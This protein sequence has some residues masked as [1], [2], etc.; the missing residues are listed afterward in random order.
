MENFV[1]RY[2]LEEAILEKDNAV[3]I[4]QRK[5]CGLQAEMRIIVK[6]NSELS[7][8]LIC[9]NEKIATPSC[10]YSCPGGSVS[11]PLLTAG[12]PDTP[13]NN[14]VTQLNDGACCCRCCLEDRVGDCSTGASRLA[15]GGVDEHLENNILRGNMSCLSPSDTKASASPRPL[16]RGTC[17]AEL[18]NIYGQNTKNLEEQLGNIESEVRTMQMELI[19][20]QRERNQLDQQRKLFKC[21]GPCVPCSCNPTAAEPI[22]KTFQSLNT[23]VPCSPSLQNGANTIFPTKMNLPQDVNQGCSLNSV[24]SV[25]QCNQ[26][27][28]RDL[29]EQYARLQDDYKSKLCEVSCLRSDAEKM[30]QE[31]RDVKEEKAKIENKLIDLQERLKV[32]EI[33]K[34]KLSGNKEQMIEQ[35]QALIVA[36]QR[37]RDAQDELDELRSLTQDQC[38]QLE[39]YRNK[40]LMAQQKVEEQRHQLD[41][42]ELDNVRM[43]ENVTLEIGRV[44]NQF[45]DKLAELAPLPD[46]LKQT[47]LKLQE[48]QQLR[49]ISERHCDDLSREIFDYKDKIESIQK[50]MDILRSENITL[51]GDCGEGSGKCEELEK[52]N[53]E[54][55]TENDRLRNS[56][57]RF[58][59]QET[60]L[61]KCIDEKLHEVAQ[62][63]SLLEQVRE[64]SARQVS[65]T[66]ERSEMMRKTMLNQISEM[67]RQLAQCRATAR[68]AQKDRDEIRQKMQGQINNLNEAFK[69]AQGRITS[70]Q[71]HVNYLKTSYSN[72]FSAQGQGEAAAPVPFLSSE[73]Q[74][75]GQGFDSCD[76][77][78]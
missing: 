28:L 32:L 52:K 65:R 60:Q 45:Q 64:D 5:V 22:S 59:E 63:T 34:N 50:E 33:E 41:L 44:K 26:Q 31:A 8:Q 1:L 75:T 16:S 18:S 77:N 54:L 4:L 40:Y 62:L 43:N 17:P 30:K 35:E 3:D 58:E 46:I 61:K 36:K 39:D 66:K 74:T 11:S 76:C 12:L 9:L 2:K 23:C 48:S 49:Q 42:M 13:Y 47:Q 72:I 15:G 69:H 29:K 37:F 38:A 14:S 57:V 10:C 24:P 21:A 7:R 70:L 67:E 71:G 56:L 6:E 27:Q 51:Q 19:N 68:A 20:V 53:S 73:P 55:R 78:Y 25:S